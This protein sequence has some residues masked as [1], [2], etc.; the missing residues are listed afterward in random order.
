M[1]R[2]GNSLEIWAPSERTARQGVKL[3]NEGQ[4]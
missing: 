2:F 4:P 3:L 1:Q